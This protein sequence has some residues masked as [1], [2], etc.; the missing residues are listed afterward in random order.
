[1]DNIGY[2]ADSDNRDDRKLELSSSISHWTPYTYL[3]DKLRTP[4]T[5]LGDKLWTSYT[6]LSDNLWTSYTNLSDNLWTS[7]INLGD[8]RHEDFEEKVKNEDEN[9]SFHHFQHV[10]C[11]PEVFFHHI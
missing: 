7:Y 6:Y 9:K 2:V 10:H 4:Y 8:N 5:N 1:M 3:S 11:D